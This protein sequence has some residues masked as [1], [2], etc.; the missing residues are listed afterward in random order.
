MSTGRPFP[1][2]RV[3]VRAVRKNHMMCKNHM[4]GRRVASQRSPMIRSGAMPRRGPTV[5]R[6]GQTANHWT[7]PPFHFSSSIP[8][9]RPCLLCLERPPPNADT[10][11]MARSSS[12]ACRRANPQLTW[13]NTTLQPRCAEAEPISHSESFSWDS[14]RIP[15]TYRLGSGPLPAPCLRN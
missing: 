12:A 9:D 1:S 15:G 3:T 10:R 13:E 7:R 11:V 6:G 5:G 8:I 4:R 2:V 14:Y